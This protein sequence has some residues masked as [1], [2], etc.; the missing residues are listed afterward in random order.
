MLEERESNRAFWNELT[1]IHE[2]SAFYDVESFLRGRNTLHDIEIKELGDVEGKS[3]LHMQCHFGMDTLSWAR[4]GAN[5]T[6][7][8]FSDKAVALAQK[9]AGEL[10]LSARFV[11]TDIFELPQALPEQFDIV[12]TSYGVLCWLRDLPA[13]GRVISS[14]LKPGGTFLIVEEHPLSNILDENCDSSE[15][16]IGYSY[17]DES[18]LTFHDRHSY[19][20]N[21]KLVSQPVHYEWTHTMEEIIMS[22]LNAGLRI[23]SYKEYPYSMYQKFP[24]LS[25]GSDNW[26]HPPAGTIPIP[27]LFSLRATK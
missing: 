27:W 19:A 1:E 2:Q 14:M 16:R 25:K 6:G 24:W 18:M 5:V 9:L 21:T 15:L 8:D 12:F 7:A 3:L 13:W 20:D 11:Q 17:F 26:W 23:D 22:L 4:L 10:N